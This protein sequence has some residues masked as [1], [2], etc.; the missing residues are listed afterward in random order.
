MSKTL[1]ETFEK[2]RELLIKGLPSSALAMLPDLEK[3]IASLQTQNAELKKGIPIEKAN[4]KEN[5]TY[6]HY[7]HIP[8]IAGWSDEISSWVFFFN[9]NEHHIDKGV[10]YHLPTAVKEDT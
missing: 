8:V 10:L 2:F 5:Y 9:S 6:F 7:D 1:D 3:Q 4:K